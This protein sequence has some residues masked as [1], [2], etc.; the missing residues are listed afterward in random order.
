MSYVSDPRI[1]SVFITAW[2]AMSIVFMLQPDGEA[3]WRVADEGQNSALNDFCR[4]NVISYKSFNPDGLLPVTHYR[5]T[6]KVDG[7]EE[8][9]NGVLYSYVD[10]GEYYVNADEDGRQ[11]SSKGERH[12]APLIIKK[13]RK[14]KFIARP[15][16]E[17]FIDPIL[18]PVYASSY[19]VSVPPPRNGAA[20]GER[21]V[22]RR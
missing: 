8:S 14:E 22:P 13:K 7:K 9:L 6:V 15:Y 17:R 19:H 5:G 4:I 1:A 3:Y 21:P 12:F 18:R 11:F 10:N 2:L 20:R 16:E